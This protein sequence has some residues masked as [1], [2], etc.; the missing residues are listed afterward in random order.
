[1]KKIIISA[2][3]LVGFQAMAQQK[4][5]QDRNGN[6]VSI[7]K[8]DTAKATG[9]FYIDSKGVLCPVFRSPGGKLYALRTSKN[10]K[11]YKFYIKPDTDTLDWEGN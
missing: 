11:V 7:V 2:L 6:F 8:K 9:K 3:L 1:M 4:V 10:G 5:T